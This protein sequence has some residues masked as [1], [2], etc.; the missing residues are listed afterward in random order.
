MYYISLLLTHCLQHL[1]WNLQ[2][3]SE[4]SLTE[5]FRFLQPSLRVYL[6]RPLRNCLYPLGWLGWFWNVFDKNRIVE[7]VR[8]GCGPFPNQF[9]TWALL[10]VFF[11]H[12]WF[13]SVKP[14]SVTIL[15]KPSFV[16][17]GREI[18]VVCQS[19]SG[20]PPPKLTWWLGS[21]MLKS[22]EEVCT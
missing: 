19:L 14:S 4:N 10:M 18:K 9:L 13:L 3:T 16:S 12:F 7:W 15:E 17:A 20:Y 1:V 21:K 8:A 2:R 11:I 6:K 5:R 22:N